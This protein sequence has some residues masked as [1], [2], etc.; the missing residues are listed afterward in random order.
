MS[1]VA[2]DR[3]KKS[4]IAPGSLSIAMF[5]ASKTRLNM[6]MMPGTKK[7]TMW[8]R[9]LGGLIRLLIWILWMRFI[10]AYV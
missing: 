5:N 8:S 7:V 1:Q 9:R 2:V 3:V 4:G 10:D 6:N